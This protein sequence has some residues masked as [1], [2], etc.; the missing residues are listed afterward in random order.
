MQVPTGRAGNFTA[1]TA[2]RGWS[3]R[4][5]VTQGLPLTPAWAWFRGI[6]SPG[7]D[8]NVALR[9]VGQAAEHRRRFAIEYIAH[10]AGFAGS[11][12]SAIQRRSI[13]SCKHQGFTIPQQLRYS[14]FIDIKRSGHSLFTIDHVDTALVGGGSV[15]VAL[16]IERHSGKV[17]LRQ[18]MD[19][20]HATVFGHVKQRATAFFG[21]TAT[22]VGD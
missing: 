4:S 7:F 17:G 22:D 13:V 20:F 18:R 14:S 1:T 5:F 8:H 12:T 19:L 11:A 9:L 6:A 21:T 15:N 16:G 10:V 3:G 2:E